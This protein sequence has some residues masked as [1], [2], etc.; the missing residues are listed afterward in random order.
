MSFIGVSPAS[1]SPASRNTADPSSAV[2]AGTSSSVKKG[3]Y[4][5]HER[6][7]QTGFNPLRSASIVDASEMIYNRGIGPEGEDN[8]R[9]N[10][11][12]FVKVDGDALKVFFTNPSFDPQAAGLAADELHHLRVVSKFGPGWAGRVLGDIMATAAKKP[13]GAYF[14][15]L[16][17]HSGFIGDYNLLDHHW[18]DGFSEMVDIVRKHVQYNYDIDARGC[19][20]NFIP[21]FF[22]YQMQLESAAGIISMP[23]LEL[24]LCLNER[25]NNG[26]HE[27][28]WFASITAAKDYHDEFLTQR[29]GKYPPYGPVAGYE[30]LVKH[31]KKLIDKG[32]LAVGI[33]HPAAAPIIS[34]LGRVSVGDWNLEELEWHVKEE[35]HG[36]GA[37]NLDISPSNYLRFD[38]RRPPGGQLEFGQRRGRNGTGVKEL[39]IDNPSENKYFT[40]LLRKWGTGETLLVE[41]LNMAWAQEMREKYGK[42]IYADQ[43]M[44][45]FSKVGYDYSIHGLG[46]MYNILDFTSQGPR[47]VKPTPAEIVALMQSAQARERIKT[48]IPYDPKTGDLLETRNY[49]ASFWERVGEKWGELKRIVKTAPQIWNEITDSFKEMMQRIGRL[50]K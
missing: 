50:Y 8:G 12:V 14:I 28:L 7:I 13:D 49:H 22:G 4:L 26:P 25:G 9:S 15:D 3:L 20:N 35:V 36:V 34:W 44:H 43:D 42:F 39:R 40:D 30:K 6:L 19:H 2:P 1:K 23:S 18:D 11:N 47:G 46:K 10:F 41:A 17:G 33:A 48:F 24:T 5:L 45:D 37:F 16:H 31:N 29:R 32:M 38:R 21:E 27:N